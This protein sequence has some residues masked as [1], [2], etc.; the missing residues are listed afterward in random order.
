MLLEVMLA[1]FL[2]VFCSLRVYRGCF[3]KQ[4]YS[5]LRNGSLANI[6]MKLFKIGGFCEQLCSR[7]RIYHD[8]LLE[9]NFRRHAIIAVR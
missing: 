3:M 7:E 2:S 1:I 4:H 5:I 9:G 8:G 6:K